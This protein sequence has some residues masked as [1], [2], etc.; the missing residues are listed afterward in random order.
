MM[1]RR[2]SISAS[3]S[4]FST[5]VVPTSTGRP[6]SVISTI[7]SISAV[8][9]AFSVRNTRSASSSRTIGRWVGIDDH[10]E[11]VDLVE[12]L[13]LGHRRAGHAGQLLVQAEV[14]LEGDR[15]EGHRLTLDAQALLGLDRLVETLRPA[16]A[17]H[18]APGELVDDDDLAVLDDVVA[19]TLV[20]RVGLERLLEVARQARIGVEH[21]VDLE[22]A[23]DLVDALLGRRDG[24][25][26]EIDEV[27]AVRGV[28][29][30]PVF[31]SPFESRHEARELVVQ[32]LRLLGL[33]A[34]D[35]RRARLVDEDVVDLVDDREVALALNALSRAP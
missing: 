4:L 21:V 35:Q 13:L 17:G 28:A 32:V 34:D 33:A 29:I 5:L 18:L 16:T 25:L 27:V 24:V 8:N 14:V 11:P 22:Q 20:E 2:L 15:G 23:L 3:T 9:F 1:P 6:A 30:L 12:L 31:A 10:L 26:L 19:V 7:S